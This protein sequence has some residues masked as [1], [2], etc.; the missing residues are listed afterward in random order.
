MLQWLREYSDTLNLITNVGML[1]VW[2]GYLHVF[3][4]LYR[5]QTTPSILITRSGGSSL[6]ARCLLCNMS[7]DAIYLQS[8]VCTLDEPGA[9]VTTSITDIDELSGKS[10]N[11]EGQGPLKSGS[12]L[13]VGRFGDLLE[14]LRTEAN[15]SGNEPPSGDGDGYLQI[16][17]I[18]VYGAE[19][20][21]VSAK[22]EFD[23]VQREDATYLRPRS[24]ETRQVRSIIERR[25]LR[26]LL[27]TFVDGDQRQH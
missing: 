20:L 17:V 27:E 26:A 14:R 21:L 2:L 7:S 9:S 11:Q 4:L 12:C 10:S 16:Q 22:R 8:L 5:R 1:L 3:L 13:D 18:A 24:V 15:R 19:D 25:R 23:V 6:D